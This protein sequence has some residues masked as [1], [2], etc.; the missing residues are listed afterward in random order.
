M[1]DK[2]SKLKQYGLVL[3]PTA[4]RDI[5]RTKILLKMDYIQTCD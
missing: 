5:A 3:C 4:A 2:E 1:M